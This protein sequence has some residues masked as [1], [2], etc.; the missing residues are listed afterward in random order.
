[1]VQ[2]HPDRSVSTH[3]EVRYNNASLTNTSTILNNFLELDK[4][5]VTKLNELSVYLTM[6]LSQFLNSYANV[7]M[8]VM[9]TKDLTA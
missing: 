5:P 2:A 8:Q 3:L 4:L 7:R 1:M 9:I 6:I